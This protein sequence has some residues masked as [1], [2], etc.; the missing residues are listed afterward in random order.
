MTQPA[1]SS[2]ERLAEDYRALRDAAA[3]VDLK[4][5]AAL[6]LTGPDTREFLQGTATQDLEI[7]P[8]PAT[9]ARTLFLTEKGR[10]VAHAW[11]SFT[12]PP[13]ES[14]PS[15][16]KAPAAILIADEG[17]KGTLRTHL[18]RFRIMEDVEL[19]GPDGMSRLLGIAGPDRETLANAIAAKTP[20]A[21]ALHAAPLS[22]VL[23]PESLASSQIPPA[24]DPQ[25]F[26]AWRIREGMPLQSQDLDADRIA[27][28]L[29]L[30]EAISMTKGC[31]VGQEVVARTTHRGK[32]RR[33]RFGFRFAW[34]GEPIP[35]RTELR[36]GG[37]IA[38]YVTST[39]HE[40]G[41][42]HGLGMGYI[43]PELLDQG[44]DILA[45]QGEK[46]THL[47]PHSWPL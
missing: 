13:P 18:E 38:G 46:T 41:T 40:P 30:P 31:Y 2:V 20:G 23:I 5:W 17:A 34:S 16:G 15:H 10:S 8:P 6:R 37:Q 28:E 3:V 35:S 22:F 39:A 47:S 27:T 26:E 36:S 29:L 14:A 32:L 21:T 44:L 7:P 19:E 42:Q 4:N 1:S 25:A 43:A 45:I 12:D 24:V 33:Q 9:A 11:V